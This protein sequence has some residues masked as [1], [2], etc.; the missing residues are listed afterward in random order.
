M[1]GACD[2]FAPP[3]Q[4]TSFLLSRP[5]AGGTTEAEVKGRLEGGSGIPELEIFFR[6]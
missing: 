2:T 3:F 1:T 6:E 5:G 4:P